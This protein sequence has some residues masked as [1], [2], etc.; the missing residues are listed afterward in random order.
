MSSRAFSVGYGVIE[1]FVFAGFLASLSLGMEGAWGFWTG[2]V[3]YR[4]IWLAVVW[5][6]APSVTLRGWLERILAAVCY[7][8][9]FWF[10]ALAVPLSP[11]QAE[12]ASS[13]LAVQMGAILLLA[14]LRMGAPW[15]NWTLLI[16]FWALGVFLLDRGV[17]ELE[18]LWLALP[19]SLALVGVP[20]QPS[21][22]LSSVEAWWLGGLVAIGWASVVC[23]KALG[24]TLERVSESILIPWLCVWCVAS[25]LVRGRRFDLLGQSDRIWSGFSIDG[26]GRGVLLVQAQRVRTVALFGLGYLYWTF[27]DFPSLVTGGLFVFAVARAAM[28]ASNSHL[29]RV[30]EQTSWLLVADLVLFTLV[31]FVVHR[32]GEAEW[33]AGAVIL[34][35]MGTLFCRRAVSDRVVVGGGRSRNERAE[36][37]DTLRRDLAARAP[38]GLA[39]RIKSWSAPE[40]EITED[41]QARAPSGFKARLLD[42][43]RSS[44]ENH[45]TVGERDGPERD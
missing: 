28:V 19:I 26:G 36:L 44:S 12:L 6:E 40:V 33:F 15:G 4:T 10:T 11:I 8:L 30:A 45:P 3:F 14:V 13:A 24:P 27:W 9:P 16:L 25:V 21:P 7:Q 34:S 5:G 22:R 42:R 23:M 29:E 32:G 17:R 38:T 41:L 35:A 20:L 2:L 39:E 1:L 18:W 31:W 43:I 37:G